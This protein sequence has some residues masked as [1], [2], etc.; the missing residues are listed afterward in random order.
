M[1]EKSDFIMPFGCNQSCPRYD[2]G[3]RAG[4]VGFKTERLENRTSLFQ[5]TLTAL[6]PKGY[7]RTNSLRTP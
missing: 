5:P 2:R 6:S 4:N 7:T 3:A 1:I